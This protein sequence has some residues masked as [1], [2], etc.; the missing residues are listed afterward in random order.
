MSELLVN[1][2]EIVIPGEEVA[3]GMDFLPSIGTFREGESIYAKNLGLLEVRKHVIKVIPLSGYYMPKRGDT[4]IGVVTNI[5][6]SG[7]TIDIGA[8]YDVNL[9][10]GEAVRGRL[11]L[12]RTDLSR[13]FDIGDII[14]ADIY[15]VTKSKII[16]LSMREHGLRKL[17]G[18]RII[19]ITPS[20]VPRLIG[21]SGSMVTM[22]KKYTNCEI[23]V[24]QN[25]Y[26]WINGPIEGQYLVEKAVDLIEKEAHLSGLTDK[27]K[28]MLEK[29][30]VKN[31]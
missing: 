30:G 27:I 15:N 11:E 17:K 1:E 9:P 4:V 10:V 23:N 28:E 24:G 21:K 6:F 12:L 26:I 5:G 8:P 2:K 31:E 29:E 20:K 22:I 13:Y 25:G 3:R 16:Q 19:K 14:V 7:W 18:G